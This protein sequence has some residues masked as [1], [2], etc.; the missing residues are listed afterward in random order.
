MALDKLEAMWYGKSFERRAPHLHNL[1]SA[2]INCIKRR[3]I[4]RFDRVLEEKSS[5]TNGRN[6]YLKWFGFTVKRIK[7][8]NANSDKMAMVEENKQ[9]IEF[10]KKT[11]T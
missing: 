5:L 2:K 11:F 4:K 8:K 6:R 3:K 7:S 9:L 1:D 10:E